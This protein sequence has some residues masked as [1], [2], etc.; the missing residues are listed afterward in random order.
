MLPTSPP[1]KLNLPYYLHF[2]VTSKANLSMIHKKLDLLLKDSCMPYE[3]RAL[4]ADGKSLTKKYLDNDDIIISKE[5]LDLAKSGFLVTS[6]SAESLTFQNLFK[7]YDSINELLNSIIN[8]FQFQQKDHMKNSNS[9]SLNTS[10]KLK[11]LL[12]PDF[13]QKHALNSVWQNYVKILLYSIFGCQGLIAF[14]RDHQTDNDLNSNIKSYCSNNNHKAKNSNNNRQLLI[15][16]ENFESA[17]IKITSHWLIKED[18]RM[19]NLFQKP[20]KYLNLDHDLEL[21]LDSDSGLIS[22]LEMNFYGQVKVVYSVTKHLNFN[23]CSEQRKNQ[24][25]FSYHCQV[26]LLNV[27]PRLI[28]KDVNY[29][30]PD[31]L[32]RNFRHRLGLSN[33]ISDFSVMEE[34]IRQDFEQKWTRRNL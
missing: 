21:E 12:S 9:N 7:S 10:Q 13:L 17:T 8:A 3:F 33:E 16:T 31:F 11:T 2:I 25:T 32:H 22:D 14:D 29:Q 4:Q 23:T 19:A 6:A 15:D 24:E 18:R 34:R 26:I 20:S 1:H 5:S 28:K 30:D 27:N